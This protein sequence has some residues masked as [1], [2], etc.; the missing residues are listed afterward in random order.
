MGNNPIR[1]KD[2]SGHA[3][4]CADGDLGGG[5]GSAGVYKPSAP[6]RDIA[7][8]SRSRTQPPI[9]YSEEDG[10]HVFDEEYQKWWR[11]DYLPM[12]GYNTD[13][14]IDDFLDFTS[15]IMLPVI[16]GIE[17]YTGVEFLGK[18][19]G[20]KVGFGLDFGVQALKDRNR[21][22]LTPVQRLARATVVASQGVSASSLGVYTA[23]AASVAVIPLATTVAVKTQNLNLAT[24]MIGGT[25][26]AV[27]TGITWGLGGAYDAANSIVFPMLDMGTYP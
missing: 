6:T 14:Q 20:K 22:D 19:L 8:P 18:G 4:A 7:P 27:Y 17:G 3:Q 26:V 15:D 23:S 9:Y 10:L 11:E 12:V 5:C 2:P 25:W 21:S 16:D 13:R 24:V 1:F